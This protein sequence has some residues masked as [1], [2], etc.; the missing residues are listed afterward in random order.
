MRKLDFIVVIYNRFIIKNRKFVTSGNKHH[1]VIWFEKKITLR[2]MIG[3][4]RR[5]KV[6]KER[7]VNENG[8]TVTKTHITV[9]PEPY[10][11]LEEFK[12]MDRVTRTITSIRPQVNGP[13]PLSS[14]KADR[15]NNNTNIKKLENEGTTGVAEGE[16]TGVAEGEPNVITQV[17]GS[18]SGNDGLQDAQNNDDCEIRDQVTESQ[19]GNNSPPIDDNKTKDQAMESQ[20]GNNIPQ[21]VPNND[22]YK[23]QDG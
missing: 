17:M 8:D 16:T 22:N 12:D 1:K 4:P 9:V 11:H 15:E 5:V 23:A 2:Q 14:N 19:S 18:Q 20:S 7:S 13:V 3:L 6:S 21:Y 10:D